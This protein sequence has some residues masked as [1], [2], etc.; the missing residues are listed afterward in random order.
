MNKENINYRNRK[1]II[2]YHPSWEEEGKD[3][4]FFDIKAQVLKN[5]KWQEVIPDM[6]ATISTM[7]TYDL[8]FITP[9]DEFW[10]PDQ[11]IY[12]NDDLSP[13]PDERWK[14][15][16]KKAK[17]KIDFYRKWNI[18]YQNKWEYANKYYLGIC[19]ERIDL[20]NMS[21]YETIKKFY[22]PA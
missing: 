20:F 18:A 4:F 12:I 1:V 14:N 7:W 10:N 19:N 2:S 16:I 13:V 9:P 8:R 3:P 15:A 5:G 17:E 22:Q 6:D 11:W 21:A